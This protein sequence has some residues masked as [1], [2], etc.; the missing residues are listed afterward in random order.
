MRKA[1][2]TFRGSGTSRSLDLARVLL[3]HGELA[4]RLALR[5]ILQAG[6]YFVDVAASPAEAIAKLDE[7]HYELVLSGNSFGSP[8]AARN[9]LAYARVK[10]YRPAT[11][12]IAS[13]E[14]LFKRQPGRGNYQVAIHTENLP[15]LLGEVAELIGA[16]ACRRYRPLRQAAV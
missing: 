9:V 6:G 1:P 11:A 16:R 8:Q 10:D 12:L 5:T 2:S 15:N 14:P 3:V 7:G 4:P 13:Y